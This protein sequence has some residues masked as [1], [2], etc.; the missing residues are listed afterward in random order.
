MIIPLIGEGD[1]E[2]RDGSGWNGC[3]FRGEVNADARG[4]REIRMRVNVFQPGLRCV[5]EIDVRH[6]GIEE[7]ECHAEAA[8]SGLPWLQGATRASFVHSTV[9]VLTSDGSIAT[10][11]EASRLERR[12]ILTKPA[13]ADQI[14]PRSTVR[15][16]PMKPRPRREFLTECGGNI[17]QAAR[18]LGI[19]R[20]SL[21]R[22]LSK[23]PVSR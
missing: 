2:A 5:D 3:G 17:S 20:R 7:V 18:V 16:R 23:R 22:K 21:Q 11:V 6:F 4:S 15:N 14:V 12:A 9:V 13:D 10:A 1:G 19:Y 8:E